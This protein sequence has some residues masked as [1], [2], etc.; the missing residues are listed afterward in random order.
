[1]FG[2]R[3]KVSCVEVGCWFS[4]F[5]LCCDER[6]C[7]RIANGILLVFIIVVLKLGLI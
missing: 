2:I 4:F 7:K 1:M 6:L 3:D 5:H